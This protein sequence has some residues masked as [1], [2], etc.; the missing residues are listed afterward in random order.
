MDPQQPMQQPT[1]YYQ[2]QDAAQEKTEPFLHQQ[3]P[4]YQP[5]QADGTVPAAASSGDTILSVKRSLA[6]VVCAVLAFLFLA[7]IGLSAG[8]G[9]SQRDL[10]QAKSDLDMTQAMLSSAMAAGYVSWQR[11]ACP[12]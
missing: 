9:V 5:Y 4:Y 1:Q 10:H 3:Q 12:C 7:V 6:L 2:L 8:L 11:D